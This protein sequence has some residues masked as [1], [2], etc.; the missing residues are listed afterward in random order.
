[1]TA[2]TSNDLQERLRRKMQTCN[3]TEVDRT[4]VNTYYA[5]ALD[6]PARAS[7]RRDVTT[8][9]RLSLSVDHATEPQHVESS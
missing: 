9:L 5:Y 2:E 1:M 6:A 4:R 7:K 8:E 3:V